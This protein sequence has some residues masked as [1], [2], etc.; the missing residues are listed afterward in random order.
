QN[1]VRSQ[2]YGI[3][4]AADTATEDSL[5]THRRIIA[6][7]ATGEGLV[8]GGPGAP[9]PEER[10]TT[11]ARAANA[12]ESTPLELKS[13]GYRYQ[14]N[15]GRKH[16]TPPYEQSAM[17]MR[18]AALP[19]GGGWGRHAGRQSGGRPQGGSNSCDRAPLGDPLLQGHPNVF[20]D[21]GRATALSGPGS[22]LQG[23][24]R[25]VADS[26]AAGSVVFSGGYRAGDGSLGSGCGGG[27]GGTEKRAAAAPARHEDGP[28]RKELYAAN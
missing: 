9:D 19:G 7:P 23:L 15:A 25:Q 27:G 6:E 28:R 17:V 18:Q 14:K 20:G 16:L 4:P 13:E 24:G 21:R 2:E 10:F 22:F 8:L 11:V 12:R 1:L 5:R 3:V 26:G